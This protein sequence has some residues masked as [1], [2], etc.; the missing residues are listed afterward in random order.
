MA[1]GV[2]G[3]TCSDIYTKFKLEEHPVLVM[4]LLGL[5]VKERYVGYQQW[6]F[7]N[8]SLRYPKSKNQKEFSL[9]KTAIDKI[10][11][12]KICLQFC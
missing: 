8:R 3:L 4:K 11:I 9:N 6:I 12:V 2:P 7:N 1:E 5:T 10:L